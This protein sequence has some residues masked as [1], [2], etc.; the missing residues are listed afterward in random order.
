GLDHATSARAGGVPAKMRSPSLS[1]ALANLGR[2]RNAGRAADR[3]DRLV[4]ALSAAGDE[5]LF[6]DVY[7][8]GECHGR[9][10]MDIADDDVH[11]S[12]FQVPA[13]LASRC[14]KESAAKLRCTDCHDPH[15]DAVHGDE[16]PYV[17]VC[18]S[19]HSAETAASGD[20]SAVGPSQSRSCP[21]NAREG[22]IACHMPT[23]S[24]AYR[25][26]FT[27]HRIGVY[28]ETAAPAAQNDESPNA[29]E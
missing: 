15:D 18:L 10:Q 23:T 29:S 25:S 2:L 7:V 11:L 28:R 1:D 22:C 12:R 13:L 24:P 9:H 16:R 6:R 20:D 27:H 19:C 26:Q 17:A 21:V 4:R 14:Y 3:G 8:C 5:R